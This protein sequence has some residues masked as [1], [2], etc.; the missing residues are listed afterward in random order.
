MKLGKRLNDKHVKDRGR[1][2]AAFHFTFP[3]THI[4]F[5]EFEQPSYTMQLVD[6]FKYDRPHLTAVT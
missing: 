6:W 4:L 3:F 1:Y 5:Q 2:A